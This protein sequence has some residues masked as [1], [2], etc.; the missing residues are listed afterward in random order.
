[1]LRTRATERVDRMAMTYLA[2][3]SRRRRGAL[4][5]S[6]PLIDLVA[7]E[8]LHH[9]DL[10][11]GEREILEAVR[12]VTLAN[13]F[14]IHALVQAVDYIVGRDLPGAFVECGT[15]RGGCAM[16]MAMR[17]EQLGVRDRDIYLFDTFEGMPKPER[18]DDRTTFAADGAKIGELFDN[19]TADADAAAAWFED[20][21]ETARTNVESTGFPADRLHLVRGKVEDTIPD[22][23]PDEIALLRLDTDWYESTKHEFDHLYPRLCSGGVLVVDDYGAFSGARDATDEYFAEHGPVLLHRVNFTVRQAVKP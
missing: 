15:Y 12:G 13:E 18:P 10:D 23:A 2:R 1:M 7:A 21:E 5:T 14:A 16:A 9:E 8:Y 22:D 3:R 4:R 6:V 17:L 20:V 11:T 19:A